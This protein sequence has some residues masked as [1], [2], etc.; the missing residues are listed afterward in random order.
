MKKKKE[1]KYTYIYML[2]RM[3]WKIYRNLGRPVPLWNDIKRAPARP[4][5]RKRAPILY[6]W[7]FYT[8][9]III[10]HQLNSLS[11]S[12]HS[13]FIFLLWAKSLYSSSAPVQSKKSSDI[14]A[15]NI[16]TDRAPHTMSCWP[17]NRCKRRRA[18]SLWGGRLHAR[19]HRVEPCKKCSTLFF[20]I[21]PPHPRI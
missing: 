21:S 11:L 10:F 12:L 16:R 14:K 13:L 6:F 3:T 17:L 5:R 9:E 18:F 7:F 4:Q 2:W 19:K 15:T 8:V 1:G 20:I